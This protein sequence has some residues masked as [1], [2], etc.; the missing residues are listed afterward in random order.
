MRS[1]GRLLYLSPSKHNTDL[2]SPMQ[3]AAQLRGF[4][5]IPE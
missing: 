1:T 4:F 3:K 2:V 5:N